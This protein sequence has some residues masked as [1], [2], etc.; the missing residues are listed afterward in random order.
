MVSSFPTL[1]NEIKELLTILPNVMYHGCVSKHELYESWKTADVW[2]Y[3]TAFSETFCVTALEAAASKTLVVATNLAGLQHTVGDRGILFDPMCS[4][5]QVF[6]LLKDTLE[7]EDL[8]KSLIER[9]YEWAKMN[10]WAFQASQLEEYLLPTQFEFNDSYY[11]W[12]HDIDKRDLMI[13]ILKKSILGGSILEIGD[14]NGLSLIAMMHEIPNSKAIVLDKRNDS[15]KK[16]FDTNMHCAG[17]KSRVT[18]LEMEPLRGL[19]ELNKRGNAFD[20]IYVNTISST[21]MQLYAELAVAW[22]I[23]SKN[24]V[25]IVQ[26]LEERKTAIWKFMEGKHILNGDVIMAFR[27]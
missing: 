9:N 4:Q 5:N 3:P 19:L 24:G 13:R 20:L 18:L 23:L 27:K 1:M 2:F 11:S 17:I 25:L 16:S 12:T 10:T 14:Q 7:N 26:L 21:D 15:F 8:K 22:E 6:Q